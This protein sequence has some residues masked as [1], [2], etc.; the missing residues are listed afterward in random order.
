MTTTINISLPSTMYKDAKRAVKTERY[1]SISELI[2]DALR[3]SL[4]KEVTENGFKPAFEEHVL[5]A[6]S[7]PDL[8]D[9]WKTEED[10]KNYF[11]NLK[12]R[13]NLKND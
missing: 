2:R 5:A 11:L 9:V 3:K 10:I 4:Y 8:D 1:V 7:E 6:A 13:P 12:S